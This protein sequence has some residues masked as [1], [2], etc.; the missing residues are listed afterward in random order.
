LGE[1]G[2][3]ASQKITVGGP[4]QETE[5]RCLEADDEGNTTTPPAA[6]MPPPAPAPPAAATEVMAINEE[7]P[8]EMVLE[9]EAPE[10]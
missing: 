8:V 10:A 1:H 6:T 7:D 3:E 2:E 9:Q 5:G 4:M